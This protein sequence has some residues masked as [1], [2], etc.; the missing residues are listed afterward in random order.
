MCPSRE[1]KEFAWMMAGD[2]NY[3][4]DGWKRGLGSP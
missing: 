2:E 3:D 4:P 1:V